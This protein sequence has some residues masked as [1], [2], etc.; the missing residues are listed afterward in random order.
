MKVLIV[1]NG[2]REHS[3]ALKIS[4]SP[5]V[6]SVYVAPGNA[7]THACA[8]NIDIKASDI[9]AL[10]DFAI[11]ECVDLVVAGSET[12]L[13]LGLENMVK[14]KSLRAG[15]DVAFFGP[16]REC[17]ML[18]A[19]KDLAKT[20]MRDAGV[21]TARY[22]SFTDFDD[23][24]SFFSSFKETFRCKMLPV[25]KADGL[26]AGKGVFLPSSL[27]EGQEILCSIMKEGVLGVSGAKV[28][29]EERLEGEEISLLAFSDGENVAPLPIAKDHKRLLDGDE[30]ANT[31]GMGAFAP[32]PRYSYQD[33][34]NLA[35]IAINPIVSEMR[36]R[37]TPYKGVLYAGLI[38]CK[39]G[40]KV[41]EYNCRF[42]DPETQV[43]ME[44]LQ[45]DIVPTLLA[46]DKGE[47]PSALPKWKSETAITVVLANKGYPN[48]KIESVKLDSSELQESS[49]VKIIHAGTSFKD[50]RLMAT[51]GRVLCVTAC[52]DTLEEAEKSVYD[53]IGHITFPHVQYRKDI[54]K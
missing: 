24:L 2:G 34:C 11:K 28:V 10:S 46:C 44:L 50:G 36:K 16:S 25:I 38:M 35:D 32:H 17:A 20:V 40:A 41:L 29:I 3:L 27:A 51:G 21:P 42:G 53:R 19:S 13:A 26:A 49:C 8:Q 30:G 9:E 47:L 52:K 7:G 1:G 48:G 14:E 54:A 15:L 6:S 4:S 31:G 39:D 18:E 5:L 33:A 12:P 43:L 45:S 23:A 37:G 22:A